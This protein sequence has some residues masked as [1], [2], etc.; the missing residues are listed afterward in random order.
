MVYDKTTSTQSLTLR[1]RAAGTQYSRHPKDSGDFYQYSAQCFIA[2]A[3]IQSLQ[4]RVQT[5][6]DTNKRD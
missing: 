4:A 2:G 1:S 3:N 5:I 6:I